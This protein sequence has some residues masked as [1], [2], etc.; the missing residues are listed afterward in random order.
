MS[1]QSLMTVPVGGRDA[2]WLAH[3]LQEAVQLEWS[4]IPPY[5]C[6]YW[7][8]RTG[9]GIPPQTAETRSTIQT[10]VIQEMLHMGLACNM[11]AG[12]GGTPNIF[13]ENFAPRYPGPLPGH[14]HEGLIIGLAGISRGEAG[15]KEQ[16][17]NFM[18]I[19]LPEEPLAFRRSRGYHTIGEFYDALGLAFEQIKP[20][21]AVDRQ[22]TNDLMSELVVVQTIAQSR[23]AIDLIKRQG[24]GTS[25]SPFVD[26]SSGQIAT[27]R[28]LAHYYRFG[29]IHAERRLRAD[30]SVPTG[31][32][33]TGDPY[34][35]PNG[36]DVYLMAEVPLGGYP[37]AD[38]F[39]RVYT[40]V[41]KL[42]H[43]AWAQGDGSKLD[44][45]IQAMDGDLTSAA[46]TLLRAGHSAPSGQGIKGPDFRF[47][48]R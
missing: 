17:C 28:Q 18:Q 21:L 48:R 15:N 10:I 13:S 24:E 5:L 2:Q 36:R 4:T 22:L 7:S 19:E 3:A 29:E 23:A 41:L 38:A 46:I 16:V 33:F 35:F 25:S 44:Q 20:K 14:V 32:S 26:A 1:I 39:D 37:E 11:L 9:A 34:P 42:L 6:A 43:D 30:S 27:A 47:L 40:D 12:I 8:I 31:W 45:A